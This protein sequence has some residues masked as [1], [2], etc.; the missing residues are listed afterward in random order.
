MW[1]CTPK[2]AFEWSIHLDLGGG[3]RGSLPDRSVGFVGGGGISSFIS[4]LASELATDDCSGV[5]YSSS[6][7]GQ[8]LSM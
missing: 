2:Y 3:L 6:S 5:K 7:R 8:A 4:T 1:F